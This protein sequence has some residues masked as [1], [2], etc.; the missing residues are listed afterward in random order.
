VRARWL[1]ILALVLAA[2]TGAASRMGS[3]P[4]EK[5]VTAI[6]P[7]PAPGGGELRLRRPR[8]P[9]GAPGPGRRLD[10]H[11]GGAVSRDPG[12]PATPDHDGRA[13]IL[14]S[15]VVYVGI[16]LALSFAPATGQL[17]LRLGMLDPALVRQGAVWQFLTYAFVHVDPLQFLFSMV[18]VYF[19][20]GAVEQQ[21]GPRRLLR[22]PFR[23]R[24]RRG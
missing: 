9:A 10:A 12:G 19:I 11:P 17:I 18:G 8:P 5:P 6:S 21:I 15:T 4:W 23:H 7:R 13:I 22:L 2:T 14:A 24:R 16:L 1:G 3:L 20:G